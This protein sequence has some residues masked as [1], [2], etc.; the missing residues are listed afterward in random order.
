VNRIARLLYET[1]VYGTAYGSLNYLIH[2]PT[3]L[4][5]ERTWNL[6]TARERPLRRFLRKNYPP[7]FLR[8]LILRRFARMAMEKAIPSI[9]DISNDFYALFLDKRYMFYSCADH[10]AGTETLEEAQ[11]NKVRFL[12][13]L[14]QPKPGQKILELGCGWGSMMR[15]VVEQTGDRDNLTGY[16]LSTAQRDHI[17]KNLGFNVE[18]KN[19]ATSEYPTEAYDTLYSIGAW[20]AIRGHEAPALLRRLYG[21]LKPGGRFVLHFFCRLAEPLPPTVAAAQLFWPGHV[22]LSYGQTAQEFE[23]AGF[24]IE[25][26]SVHD[27]RPTLRQWFDRLVANKEAAIAAAGVQAYNRHVVLFAVSH[28]YFDERTGALFRFALRKPA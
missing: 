24:R 25:H 15:A 10:D 23:R 26:T 19:F 20:E 12:L 28:R 7:A 8:P 4:D 5:E 27:Y 3:P 14:I 18:I 11:A 17:Q 13:N 1:A 6:I 9:Y 2:S 22:P 16:T 21:T